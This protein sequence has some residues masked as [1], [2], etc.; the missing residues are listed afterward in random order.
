[1]KLFQ[2]ITYA[3]DHPIFSDFLKRHNINPDSA[4]QILVKISNVSDTAVEY[5]IYVDF[6]TP[7]QSSNDV[8][9]IVDYN[10]DTQDFEFIQIDNP[11]R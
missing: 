1:M 3:T 7:G 4:H 10:V 9:I 6:G 5:R 8:R 11:V 2:V